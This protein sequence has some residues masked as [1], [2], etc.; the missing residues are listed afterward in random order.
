MPLSPS[1]AQRGTIHRHGMF[2]RHTPP[3]LTDSPLPDRT[4]S[5]RY[6]PFFFTQPRT[7]AKSKLQD[8]ILDVNPLHF[9]LGLPDEDY[10]ASY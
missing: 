9:P 8:A 4:G 3:S 6:S 10:S 5:L 1:D 2:Q 7:D